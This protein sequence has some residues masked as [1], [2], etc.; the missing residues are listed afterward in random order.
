MRYVKL[1]NTGEGGLPMDRA[2]QFMVAAKSTVGTPGEMQITEP[3]ADGTYFLAFAN[4]AHATRFIEIARPRGVRLE[5]LM[6]LP[7]GVTIRLKPQRQQTPGTEEIVVIL[8]EGAADV[9]D[10]LFGKPP[11]RP[12]NGK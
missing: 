12:G 6:K 1:S 5:S 2:R 3:R 8:L 9:L 11:R 7:D 10:I 4:H